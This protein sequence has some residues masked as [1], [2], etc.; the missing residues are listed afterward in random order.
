MRKF[1]TS[2]L[3]LLF[4]VL[5]CNKQDTKI[6]QENEQEATTAVIA[7]RTCASQDVLEEQL[8]SDASLRKRMDDIE[9]YTKRVIQNPAA[10]R[11]ANG[12][13]E[14]PVV[15]HVIYNKAVENISDAQV[16]SQIDV[17]NEDFNNQNSDRVLAPKEFTDEQTSVGVRFVL[18]QTVRVQTKKVNF[19]TDDAV[20]KTA[21]GGSDPIDSKKYLNLW[22]CNL[23][24]SLLGYA[25]FP[26]GDPATDGVVILYSAFG[27]KSK[28]TTGTYVGNYDQGRTATHEIGHWMNLRH[29]WGDATCGTDYVDDTPQHNTSNSG[30]PSYP[31]KSTCTG[32][33]NEMTMNYMDYTYDKCMYMFTK[34]QSSRMLAVFAPGGP[35]ASFNP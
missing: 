13:I 14:I 5:S 12:P 33:P 16:R 26:G 8:V 10:F 34:G 28:A 1:S 15:V 30:C 4:L 2:L 19:G 23:G 25:Q 27:S 7:E 24:R 3:G 29:I 17:L 11:L 21:K 6:A 9:A 22:S 35:R 20:K 32:T 31:H 18:A